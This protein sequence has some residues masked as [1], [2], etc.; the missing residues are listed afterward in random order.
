MLPLYHAVCASVE[1]MATVFYISL[2]PAHEKLIKLKEDILSVWPSVKVECVAAD[3]TNETA[4]KAAFAQI[5]TALGPP[6][7]LVYN[8]AYFKMAG[9]Q[10]SHLRHH[11]I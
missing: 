5:K 2:P 9:P 6:S 1:N 4:V 8:S 11:Y 7:V 10:H 3:A